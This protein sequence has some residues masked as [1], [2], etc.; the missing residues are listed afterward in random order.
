MK[1]LK[2][3]KNFNNESKKLDAKSDFNKLWNKVFFYKTFFLIIVYLV[4]FRRKKNVY[5]YIY[6]Y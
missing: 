5:I 3:K 1:R 4:I 6:H 2:H